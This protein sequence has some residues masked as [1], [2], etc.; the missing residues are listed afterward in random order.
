MANVLGSAEAVSRGGIQRAIRSTG[1]SMSDIEQ[2]DGASEGVWFRHARQWNRVGTPLRPSAEDGE[3]MMA[4]ARP[5]LASSRSPTVVVLGVT[6]E[7][8]QLPWPARTRLLAVDHSA[9]M[10]AHVFGPQ[11]FV[12]A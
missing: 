5:Y 4:L 7:V 11:P 9:D 6:P 2:R 12:C 8:V 3:A 1:T 10:I